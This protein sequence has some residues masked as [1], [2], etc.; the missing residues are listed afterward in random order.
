MEPDAPEPG[1]VEQAVESAGEGLNNS[2]L[3]FCTRSLNAGGVSAP[4]DKAAIPWMRKIMEA[5][6]A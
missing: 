3:T 2:C 6:G 5:G 4:I 1:L